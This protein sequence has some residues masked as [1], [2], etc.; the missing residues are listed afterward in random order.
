MQSTSS[1][2]SVP[3][4]LRVLIDE[5]FGELRT[6]GNWPLRVTLEQRYRQDKRRSLSELCDKWREYHSTGWGDNAARFLLTGRAMRVALSETSW[7]APIGKLLRVAAERFVAE[8]KAT[9]AT[10]SRLVY[11]DFREGVSTD[12]EAWSLALGTC[13]LQI[14]SGHTIDPDCAVHQQHDQ[15][16]EFGEAVLRFLAVRSVDDLA[17]RLDEEADSQRIAEGDEVRGLLRWVWDNTSPNGMG[18]AYL[19]AVIAGVGERFVPDVLRTAE[20][21]NLLHRENQSAD[22]TRLALRF[23]GLLRIA[24]EQEKQQLA[25]LVGALASLC[26]T[27]ANVAKV[28]VETIKR[29]C[30]LDEERVLPLLAVLATDGWSLVS[31]NRPDPDG[32]SVRLYEQLLRCPTECDFDSFIRAREAALT[33][34]DS[35][36]SIV[37]G[38][39]TKQPSRRARGSSARESQD[40]D[41]DRSKRRTIG[42]WTLGEQLGRRSGQGR[43]YAASRSDSNDQFALKKVKL[44]TDKKRQRFVNEVRQMEQLT[45]QGAEH[46]V[47]IVDANLDEVESGSTTGYYV[48][49]K[50]HATLEERLAMLRGHV[51][52]CLKV[53]EAVLRGLHA[54]HANKVVHRD[55]KPANILF[56]DDSFDDPRLADFGICLAIDDQD[57]RPTS[58]DEFV[59]PFYFRAPEQELPGREEITPAADLYSFGKVLH[60]MLTGRQDLR[61]EELDRAFLETELGDERL[62]RIKDE[63]LSRVLIHEPKD[64][65]QDAAELRTALERVRLGERS[66]TSVAVPHRA[67]RQAFERIIADADSGRYIAA[68]HAIRQARSDFL[69]GTGTIDLKPEPVRAFLWSGA[70]LIGFVLAAGQTDGTQLFVDIRQ[71]IEDLLADGRQNPRPQPYGCL[72]GLLFFGLCFSA[73]NARSWGVLRAALT[74][75]FEYYHASGRPLR[76][77][78]YDI[79]VMFSADNMAAGAGSQQNHLRNI[80]REP[81]VAG[82]LGLA[83]RVDAAFE[84][85]GLLLALRAA[86]AADS[87]QGCSLLWGFGEEIDSVVPMLDRFYG[88]PEYRAGVASAFGEDAD[89]WLRALPE[90]LRHIADAV[91]RNNWPFANDLRNHKP[92]AHLVR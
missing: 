51:E 3:S 80:L 92:R 40:G 70:A 10:K 23:D 29:A 47:P 89:T 84:Q 26:G 6:T 86:K 52:L 55:V 75:E 85:T 25:V 61:R 72:A 7:L 78:G 87:P 62:R 30:N 21:Q 65:I 34:D 50:A 79:P 73:H 11:A 17:R 16:V 44:D 63:V 69:S 36:A 67:V 27:E 14:A 74:C 39:T 66:P 28:S 46:V 32:Q 53:G 68:A 13:A 31:V 35:M 88:D 18:P 42:A 9:R 90:R 33:P 38:G 8:Y 64:R 45:S 41:A 71:T 48:M 81:E 58:V 12:A 20:N 76:R 77:Y 82:M 54:A 49:P 2:V 5:V 91:G 4:D 15:Y 59:G 1:H 22:E 43:V 57:S 37:L 19:D 24:T 60:H 83:D 56:M